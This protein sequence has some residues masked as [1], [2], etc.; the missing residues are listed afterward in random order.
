[1][2]KLRV[3]SRGRGGLSIRMGEAMRYVG[4]HLSLRSE[5][6]KMLLIATDGSPSDIDERDPRHLHMDA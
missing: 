3:V 6:I 1:M 2:N 4:H 5:K